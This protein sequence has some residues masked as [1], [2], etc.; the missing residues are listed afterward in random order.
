MSEMNF[1]DEVNALNQA[2]QN[3]NEHIMKANIKLENHQANYQKALE[4]AKAKFGTDNFD[5]LVEI[6]RKRAE[7]ND[8]K[9]EEYKQQIEA[10]KVEVQKR[11]QLENEITQ[12]LQ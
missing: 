8:Q 7:S 1:Q 12:A 3:I 5:E 4:T 6:A 10:K 9:K 11:V 2:A